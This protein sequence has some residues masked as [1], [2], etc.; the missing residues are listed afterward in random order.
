MSRDVLGP[1]HVKYD[2][3]DFWLMVIPLIEAIDDSH[4]G[5]MFSIDYE[6]QRLLEK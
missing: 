6:F 3:Q 2:Y 4:R 1:E 5:S